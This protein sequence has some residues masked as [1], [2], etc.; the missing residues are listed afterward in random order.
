MS[1]VSNLTIP[2]EDARSIV[3]ILADVAGVEGGHEEKKQ[4]LMDGLCSLVDGDFWAW[5]LAADYVP[6]EGAIYTSIMTGGLEE[7]QIPR[8]LLALGVPD[9]DEV[10]GPLGKEI[11]ETG[12]HATRLPRDYDPDNVFGRD[13]V[14]QLWADSGIGA[15]LVCYRPVTNNCLS[16][17]GIFRKADRHPFTYREE[18]IADLILSEVV[19]LHEQGWPWE[20]AMKVPQLPNRC[21]LALN[22][23]L[24]G[25]PRK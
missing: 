8:L 19:W 24:E 13:G 25:L 21:R 1:S 18:K 11:G 17:I 3:R 20:S 12:K 4:L 7:E 10:M 22:F 2:E 23:L 15:P 9:L 5:G 16:G 6:G 14:R